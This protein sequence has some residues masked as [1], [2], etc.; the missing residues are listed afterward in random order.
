MP[1]KRQEVKEEPF[2]TNLKSDTK[3]RADVSKL[4]LEDESDARA[5]KIVLGYKELSKGQRD[6][7]QALIRRKGIKFVL[8]PVKKTK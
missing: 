8:P 5:L 7:M 2:F 4:I 6:W 1:A 3:L